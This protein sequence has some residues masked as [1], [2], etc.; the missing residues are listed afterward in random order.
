MSMDARASRGTSALL[1]FRLVQNTHAA[2]SARGPNLR[3]R[4][5]KCSRPPGRPRRVANKTLHY[6]TL[7]FIVINYP[8]P[9]TGNERTWT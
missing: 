7:L 4:S 8:S 2:I 6:G 1:A 5:E 9:T 3:R